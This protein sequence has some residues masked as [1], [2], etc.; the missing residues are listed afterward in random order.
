MAD[1]HV[2]CSSWTSPAWSGRFYPPDLKDGDRL[3]YYARYFDC[4]EVDSTFYAPPNPFVVRGWRRKTPE[5]FRFTL[6]MFRD[7]LDPK[8]AEA[9]KGIA[10][11]VEA[12]S[13]LG[14]KLSAI[15]LQFPPWYK[16]SF[17][18]HLLGTLDAL[19]SGPRYAVELRDRSWFAGA[20]HDRLTA[21]LADRRI[22]LAWSYLTYVDVPPDRT[23]DFLY[24]RFIGDHRTIPEEQH[25][26]VR[27]D[28]TKETARWAERVRDAPDGATFV[29]FN[30][31]FAGFAPASVNLFRAE[32][33][34]PPITWPYVAPA[35]TA[36]GRQT[37]LP[38]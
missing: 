29:F 3:A 16:A 32:F 12:A 30:N 27:V 15:L 31:H 8:K 14:E 36:R 11:F 28:R 20:P 26:E 6:K 25:G 13:E 17:E 22:A 35:P 5:G 2:G 1:L 19:P 9:A 21:A 4:V 10:P 37:A 33:D 7:L 38:D 18:R 23:S 24:L 34:L